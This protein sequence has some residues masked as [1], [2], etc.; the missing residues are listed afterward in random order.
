MT[1]RC[2]TC[3]RPLTEA[4]KQQ[5][6]KTPDGY[7]HREFCEGCILPHGYDDPE[8]RNERRRR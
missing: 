7:Q 1:Q 4:D 6:G 2:L 3:D 5:P 8:E